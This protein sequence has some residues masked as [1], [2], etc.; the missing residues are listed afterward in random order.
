MVEHAHFHEVGIHVPSRAYQELVNSLNELSTV[1]RKH[2]LRDIHQ[3]HPSIKGKMNELC[4]VDSEVAYSSWD[5]QQGL[6][7]TIE[8]IHCIPTKDTIF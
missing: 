3:D 1:H 2:H 6:L 5:Q 4:L 7:D 8:Q